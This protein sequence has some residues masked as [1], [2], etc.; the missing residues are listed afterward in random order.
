MVAVTWTEPNSSSTVIAYSWR[1]AKWDVE[2]LIFDQV[3]R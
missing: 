3:E 2:D 1:H